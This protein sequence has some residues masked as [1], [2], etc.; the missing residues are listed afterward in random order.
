[1]RDWLAVPA[2]P[3]GQQPDGKRTWTV[4]SH[5]GAPL[6]STRSWYTYSPSVPY[7]KRC[8]M[9]GRSHSARTMPSPTRR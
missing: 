7:G 2:Q 1:M 5:G 4:S 3:G 9:H 6:G 8:N